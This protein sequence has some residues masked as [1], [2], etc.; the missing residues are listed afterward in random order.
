MRYELRDRD[1]LTFGDVDCVYEA[2]QRVGN[3]RIDVK[4]EVHLPWLKEY[5]N[6]FSFAMQ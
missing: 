3:L 5:C 4:C 1:K 6:S 2:Q